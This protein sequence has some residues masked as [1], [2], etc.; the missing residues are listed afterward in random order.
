MNIEQYFRAA[1]S[2]VDL[3]C[4]EGIINQFSD[5]H[6][7]IFRTQLLFSVCNPQQIETVRASGVLDVELLAQV[8]EAEKHGF[9]RRFRYLFDG[10][11]DL[12]RYLSQQI[13]RAPLVQVEAFRAALDFHGYR[14]QVEA[15]HPEDDETARECQYLIED[16]DDTV[17]SYFGV[18]HLRI[19]PVRSDDI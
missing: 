18:V 19:R 16:V 6:Q 14:E 10:D 2:G 5:M 17:A 12:Y 11:I 7:R 9:L 15:M 1:T 13:G 4:V 3:E 8:A